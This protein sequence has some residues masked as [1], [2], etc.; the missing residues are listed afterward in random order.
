M[1]TV[2]RLQA[3]SLAIGLALT[4]SA[5]AQTAT[6]LDPHAVYEQRCNSCHNEHG[7]DFARQKLRLV[8]DRLEVTRTSRDL[9]ALLKK[10]HGVA[11]APGEWPALSSLFRLGLSTGGVFGLR[12]GRCHDRAVTLAREKLEI[13]DGR[14]ILRATRQELAAFLKSHHEP[15]PDEI[16]TLVKALRFS[17]ESAPKP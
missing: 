8:K 17:V 11:L 2:A 4:G 3:L 10:H 16:E 9:E 12:C 5:V 13:A 7:G 6:P 1:R 14:L 15:T